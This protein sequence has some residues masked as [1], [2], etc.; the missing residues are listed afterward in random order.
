M[1]IYEDY[2]QSGLRNFIGDLGLAKAG[3]K[4]ISKK[5]N[6][7]ILQVNNKSLN[8]VRTGLAL[9]NEVNDVPV[10]IRTLKVSGVVNKV[11]GEYKEV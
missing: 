1:N 2:I 9:I 6:K 10:S 7:G 8:E 4:F 11:K 5:S 3:L